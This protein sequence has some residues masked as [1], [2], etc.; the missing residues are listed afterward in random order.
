MAELSE[1]ESELVA[2]VRADN[3]AAMATAKPA[4]VPLLSWE[5]FKKA[6]RRKSEKLSLR[7]LA[8][9]LLVVGVVITTLFIIFMQSTA[10]QIGSADYFNSLTQQLSGSK[11]YE[12]LMASSGLSWYSEFYKFYG[13]RWVIAGAV[14]TLFLVFSALTF[15]IDIARRGIK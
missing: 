12:E 4:A 1:E 5:R 13:L 6:R 2:R 10:D 14:M 11:E 3:R 9:G 8:I 7:P 15:I